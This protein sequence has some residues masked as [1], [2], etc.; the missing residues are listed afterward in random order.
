M[1]L[2]YF[3]DMHLDK[4]PSSR[5]DDYRETQE[6]KI[7]A[8]KDYIYKY[9]VKAVLQ[10]GDFLNRDIVSSEELSRIMKLWKGDNLDLNDILKGVLFENKDIEYLKEAMEKSILPPMIGVAGNHELTGGEISSL[11]KTS[12]NLLIKSGFMTLATKENPIII[13][14]ESGFTVAITG[15]HYTHD[16]DDEDKSAYIVDRKL[17]DFHIHIVHGMLM[18][19]SFGKKFK[20]TTISEIVKTKAD[21]TINGHDHIGYELTEIDGK[22]FVNPGA[23]FRLNADKKEMNRY[24]KVLLIEMDKVNGL[25]VKNLELPAEEGSKVLTRNHIVKA[26]KKHKKLE[27][28]EDA[29]KKADLEKGIDITEIIKKISDNEKLDEEIANDSIELI[30]QKMRELDTPFNPKGEY[31]IENITL[32]NFLCHKHTSLDFREG[33]NVLYG[34]SRSGKSSVLRAIRE[35]YECYLKNPRDFI[36]YNETYFKITLTLSNGYVITRFVEKK[37]TG[38]NGYEI[39]DPNTGELNYY[40]TKALSMVQEILGLNKVKLTEKNKVGINFLNQGESWFFIGN[41]LSAPDKAKLTGVVYGTHYADGVLKDINSNL[42]KIT[43]E[44]NFYE[45]DIAKLET[46]KSK[47]D[48]IEEYEEILLRAEEKLKIAESLEEEIKSIEVL[49]DKLNQI[50]LEAKDLNN[51]IEDISKKETQCREIFE[52]LK[53]KVETFDSLNKLNQEIKSVV[54]AGREAAKV[55][56]SLKDLDK[57]KEYYETILTLTD[58]NEKEEKDLNE[59]NKINNSVISLKNDI[60]NIENLSSKLKEVDRANELLKSLQEKHDNLEK[61]NKISSE[62]KILENN[63]SS[64][65]KEIEDKNKFININLD[66]YKEELLSRG[67][68]PVCNGSINSIIVDSL[69][70][71]FQS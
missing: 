3:G 63:I 8:I 55:Q 4:I 12:L 64:N 25:V 23:P 2:L 20:H 54:L 68:C 35:V 14:D 70:K 29:L 13:K 11:D 21:L 33:L 58:L 36:F 44:I 51:L 59:Y 71:E 30:T 27:E 45:S 69:I 49:N 62:V 15:S 57:V 7:N 52:V 39:Y 47:Y 38:K 60:D 46:E 37:K 65:E 19:K 66:I 34:E 31:I 53:E 9:N 22:Y 28:I 1:N 17:G 6:R 42:K 16:I 67:K 32:E 26:L 5:L 56:N 61:I 43:S 48:Y 50:E 40:N 41:G 10:G 18:E 24:P